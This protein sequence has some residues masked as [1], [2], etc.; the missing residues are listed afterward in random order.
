MSSQPTAHDGHGCRMHFTS[1]SF[2]RLRASD[3]TIQVVE[4]AATIGRE[5]D[6]DMLRSVLDMPE[7]KLED[8]VRDLVIPPSSSSR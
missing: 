5:F 7:S 3:D 2:A 6:Q 4:A 1:H 8:A